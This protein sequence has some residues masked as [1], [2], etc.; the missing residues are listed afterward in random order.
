MVNLLCEKC[1]ESLILYDSSEIKC[2]KCAN[3]FE[4]I[5]YCIKCETWS[6]DMYDDGEEI[7]QDDLYNHQQLHLARKCPH[8]WS[9]LRY[10]HN[11]EAYLKICSICQVQTFDPSPKCHC[12]TH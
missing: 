1:N 7:D 5:L 6:P 10:D 8:K 11:R 2:E 12:N 4:G 9:I 3:E